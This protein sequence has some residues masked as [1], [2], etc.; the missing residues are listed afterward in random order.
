[1]FTTGLLVWCVVCEILAPDPPAHTHTY[2]VPG[3][4]LNKPI[5]HAGGSPLTKCRHDPSLNRHDGALVLRLS[6]QH[7]APEGV[8]GRIPFFREMATEHVH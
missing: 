5:I 8:G 6:T 4:P 3:E 7:C 1:M 2:S